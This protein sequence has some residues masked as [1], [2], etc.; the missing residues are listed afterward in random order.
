M[1]IPQVSP[2]GRFDQILLATDGSEF[3]AGAVRAAIALARASG[4]KLTA[5]TMVHGNAEYD[6]LAPR[7]VAKALV[8]A[9]D[10]LERIEAEAKSAGVE[11]ASLM[12]QGEDP[13][14]EI[15]V[16]AEELRA[17]VVVMGRRGR[18]GLA[19][20]MVGDATAKV[21][22][23]ARCSVLVVPRQAGL[24]TRRMLLASDGSRDADAAAVTAA[25]LARLLRLPMSVV[26]VKVSSHS[27]SRRAEADAIVGRLLD[28]LGREGIEADGRVREGEVVDA[29]AAAAQDAGADLIV[30]GGYGRTGWGRALL[31][32]NGERIIGKAECAVLVA[33]GA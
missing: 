29:V 12:R 33:K 17:D 14:R 28:F 11:C 9:R 19:R 22:G 16:A 8:E 27:E 20:L 7:L 23:K 31:G 24:G 21:V 4:G 26:S 6:A 15:V 2:L 3:S 25:G 10:T 30:I 13:H 18:R 5:M 32:S 1:A